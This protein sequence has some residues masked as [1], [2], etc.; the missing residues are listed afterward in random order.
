ML[1]YWGLDAER[2]FRR[3]QERAAR[4]GKEA[5]EAAIEKQ[6]MRSDIEGVLTVF[7]SEP[8]SSDEA[9]DQQGSRLSRSLLQAASD[10]DVSIEEAVRI[11]R[12]EVFR[13]A[14]AP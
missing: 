7:A 2:R 8:N 4:A 5:L 12:D 6:A 13:R 10:R 11:A 3:E 14:P 9:G 1:A